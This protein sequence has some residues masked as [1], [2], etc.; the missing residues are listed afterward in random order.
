MV[1]AVSDAVAGGLTPVPA[2]ALDGAIDRACA[3]T[4]LNVD[5]MARVT[6]IRLSLS[7]PTTYVALMDPAGA[8][9]HITLANTIV[10][11][12]LQTMAVGSGSV[13]SGIT[14]ELA[15]AHPQFVTRVTVAL[16]AKAGIA[17]RSEKGILVVSITPGVPGYS[18]AE[19]SPADLAL[20]RIEESVRRNDD[21][22]AASNALMNE[23]IEYAHRGIEQADLS[24]LQADL[25]RAMPAASVRAGFQTRRTQTAMLEA[26]RATLLAQRSDAVQ[27][28]RRAL[29]A[30]ADADSVLTTFDAQEKQYAAALGALAARAKQ[31][32]ELNDLFA[33]RVQN[34]ISTSARGTSAASLD[35]MN[36]ALAA[37]RTAAS[38]AKPQM[39]D[40]GAP[41]AEVAKATVSLNVQSDGPLA[42]LDNDAQA[43][44]PPAPRART[45][46]HRLAM[47]EISRGGTMAVLRSTP[48]QVARAENDGVIRMAQAPTADGTG[49][50]EV[51][52]PAPATAPAKSSADGPRRYSVPKTTGTRP[53]YN[54]YNPNVPA[55]QD[56]LRQIV[57]L[58]F[59]GMDLTNVVSLLAEKG[60]INVIAGTE[61]TGTVTTNLKNVPL[62]RAIEIVLRLSGL[63]IVEEAGVYRIT[64]YE[65]AIAAQRQTRM[66]FLK[67]AQADDVKKTLD[68]ILQSG[69]KNDLVSVSSNPATNVIIIAG[70]LES[71]EEL[72]GVVSQLDV[73][74]Q[75]VPT[76]TMAIKL[77][78]SDPVELLPVV[79]PL[80]SKEGKISADPR[81]R[82]II[83]SDIP[84]KVQE[85]QALIATVDLPVKSVSIDALIVDAQL[86]D[87]AQ[88]GID[89]LLNTNHLQP[90]GKPDF[91]TGALLPITN[92]AAGAGTLGFGIISDSI[93]LRAEIKARV[94]STNSE[95]LESPNIVTV[96]NKPAEINVSREIPYQELTQTS[97]GGQIASTKF[98]DVGTVLKVTPRVTHDDHIIVMLDAK[99]S[100][101]TGESVTG[102]PIEA[103]RTVT[104]TVR[105]KNGQSFYVG[106]LRGHDS[107]LK[108]RKVP[109]LGDI[110][111]LNTFFKSQDV[112]KQH[113]ELM[114]FVTCNVLP[115]DRLPE[116]TPYQQE[117]YDKLGGL[118]NSVNGTRDLVRTYTHPEE[119]RDPIYKWRRSK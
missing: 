41:D 20:A 29:G 57:N 96:E 112:T 88:T 79:T 93:N 31:Q 86:E 19:F 51:A 8:A 52:S 26:E 64:T 87:G 103:K 102:V 58:D 75:V 82:Q 106:G 116:L 89:W 37:V 84:V 56:P 55:S 27:T 50:T 9:L 44:A 111:V 114:I 32:Y 59:Q 61:V 12:S 85:I 83:V 17:L 92:P 39:A 10:L 16:N 68:D 36:N 118:P 43:A 33:Q 110:P 101:T 5:A 76:I 1:L 34:E 71:I 35:Q 28:A 54:L 72:E 53:A 40:S 14:T 115:D 66:I 90:D 77:N 94:E 99:Q 67:N 21:L 23:S 70:P 13:V 69:A 74:D 117:T 48:D 4:T 97:E 49:I 105:L 62:G 18:G 107:T 109:V 47:D 3:L 60:Q 113:R 98:K 95:L 25:V 65:E 7:R 63:G 100:N 73:A 6:E 38:E 11:P 46:E 80:I 91:T 104:N 24:L 42:A 119:Q 108:N 22:F 78:Y 30:S 81:T 2:A 15:S 45:T